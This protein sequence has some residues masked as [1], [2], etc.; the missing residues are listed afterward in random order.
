M[1]K[2]ISSN[3]LLNHAPIDRTRQAQGRICGTRGTFDPNSG[4]MIDRKLTLSIYL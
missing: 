4:D 2:K 1:P 3:F